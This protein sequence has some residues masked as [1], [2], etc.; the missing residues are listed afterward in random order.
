MHRQD[1][2]QPVLWP[3]FA[4]AG[5]TQL[6]AEKTDAGTKRLYIRIG[7]KNF[8]QIQSTIISHLNDRLPVLVRSA[9]QSNM[10][11]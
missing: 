7:D 1:I 9:F 8:E 5:P 6:N 10:T 3:P 2:T 4:T 11:G